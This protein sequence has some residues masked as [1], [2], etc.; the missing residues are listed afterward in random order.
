MTGDVSGGCER[1]VCHGDRRGRGHG[2][3]GPEAWCDRTVEELRGVLTAVIRVVVDEHEPEGRV[4]PESADRVVAVLIGLSRHVPALVPPAA[5]LPIVL[6][7]EGH[8]VDVSDA[9]SAAGGHRAGDHGRSLKCGVDVVDGLTG[10]HSHRVRLAPATCRV[11]VLIHP[12]R[13]AVELDVVDALLQ[14]YELV[15]A[16]HVRLS[17]LDSLVPFTLRHEQGNAHVLKSADSLAVDVAVDCPGLAKIRIDAGAVIVLTQ[18]DV[19]REV[20]RA[21]EVVVAL[22]DPAVVRRL[23]HDAIRPGSAVV[24][25]AVREPVEAVRAVDVRLL[26]FDPRPGR[27]VLFGEHHLDIRQRLWRP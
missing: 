6:P 13:A 12:L 7:L 23:E 27:A 22:A 3:I 18:E 5:S 16:V 4:G 17:P 26:T 9:G 10:N 25:D 11:V 24:V 2:H 19:V 14:T 15:P 20:H 1:G 8:D 21:D